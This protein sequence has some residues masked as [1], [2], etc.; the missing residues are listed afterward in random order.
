MIY[1]IDDKRSRQRDYGWGEE[2]FSLYRE[3][4]IPIWNYDDLLLY[5]NSL[6]EQGTVILFHE[7][8]LSS[9]DTELNIEIDSIKK[10]LIEKSHLIYIAFFSGSKNARYVNGHVCMLPPE[11][12]YQNLDTFISKFNKDDIDFKYLAFGENYH[13]EED[14]RRDLLNTIDAN[15][16]GEIASIEKKILFA[17]TKKDSIEHPFETCDIARDWDHFQNDITDVEL[18]Q[19]VN[20]WLKEKK[21][22]IIYI[23]LCFGNIYSDFL[24]LRL[25]LHIRLTLTVNQN[26]KVYI[27]GVTS[28]DAIFNNE[29][30][31]VLKLPNVYL[32]GADNES[33]IEAAK[34]ETH[35]AYITNELDQIHVSIPSNIGNNHS[36]ANRWAIYRWQNMLKWKLDT[37]QI[38]NQELEKSLYFKY[39]VSKFGKRN[40]FKN[41]QKYPAK[42]DG[43]EGKTIVYIDDE[44]DKG[45]SNILKQIV[46]K[47]S[48]ADFLCFDKFD[49]KISKKQ[50]LDRIN[51]FIDENDANCYLIDLRLHEDDFSENT[52]LTGH[53]IAEHIK[54]RNKGNQ[55][56]VF[57]ASN[58]IWNLKKEL[59]KIGAIGY[60]LKESPESN[61]TRDESKQQFIEFANAIKTA[62][63]LSFLKDLYDKQV[64]LKSVNSNASDLDSMIELLAIDSG[65]NNPFILNSVLLAEIVFIEHYIKVVDSLSLSKTGEGIAENVE[66]CKD[67]KNISKVTGHLFVKR[68][69]I[70]K[71]HPNV[72]DAFYSPTPIEAPSGWG[73][74]S[75][76]E[77]T[78]TIS[79]LLLYYK[80]PIENVKQYIKLK[81]IR[82]TQIAHNGEKNK[83]II[84]K[85]QDLLNF[86]VK[87]LVDFYYDVIAPI[88]LIRSIQNTK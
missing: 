6:M 88:I 51:E 69:E 49:K 63:N 66:L 17:E 45:W 5:R 27:Y 21:Y 46:E 72:V 35:C 52:N 18:D 32:I 85:Y 47:E 76:S 13:I 16:D 34:R 38:H 1:I 44:Y 26:S 14:I 84:V 62:C 70:T 74:A 57:T 43:I 73:R 58:K 67:K 33:L 24:G 4:I 31:D 25:A 59:F 75:V 8:F 78:L 82:N 22:D 11:V 64:Q 23:P 28:Y 81:L 83:D 41:D 80:L 7:S 68:E 40:K 37:P 79:S 61:Y 77:A 15:I 36:L 12:L 2:R 39:L 50:L 19:F 42:I 48:N 60:A 10:E 20:K 87:Q 71:G 53:E 86:S 29:C 56:V 9:T 55:I 30:F 54:E 3:T 65:N